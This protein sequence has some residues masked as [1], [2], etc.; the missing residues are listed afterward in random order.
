MVSII[1]ETLNVVMEEAAQLATE[2]IHHPGDASNRYLIDS[3]VM[4]EAIYHSLG[5]SATAPFTLLDQLPAQ[6]ESV[7][8]RLAVTTNHIDSAIIPGHEC[9]F[10]PHSD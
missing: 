1:N 10:E 4:L 3:K 9:L 2:T 6:D 5:F 8:H 7:A